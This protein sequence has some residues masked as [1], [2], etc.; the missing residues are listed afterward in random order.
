MLLQCVGWLT[1]TCFGPP[2]NIQVFHL[3]AGNQR[4]ERL[5]VLCRARQL[6]GCLRFWEPAKI[7]GKHKNIG[8]QDYILGEATSPLTSCLLNHFPDNG[9]LINQQGIF[10]HRTSEVVRTAFGRA[11]KKKTEMLEEVRWL[12]A[13][14]EL[15]QTVITCCAA[16]NLCERRREEWGRAHH[17]FLSRCTTGHLEQRQI[18]SGC[19]QL[20]CIILTLWPRANLQ[21]HKAV[22]TS[23]WE[24]ERLH[25]VPQGEEFTSL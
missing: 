25:C 22:H 10:N 16:R 23:L 21:P 3:V 7:H 17:V 12:A 9:H 1:N 19:V 5:Y 4:R 24:H 13:L 6:C 11:L 2:R 18:D 20:W 14:K 15:G 8:Q